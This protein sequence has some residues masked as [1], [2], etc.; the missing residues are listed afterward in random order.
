MGWSIRVKKNIFGNF[1]PMI[2]MFIITII[3]HFFKAKDLLIIG[4]IGIIPISWHDMF[5]KKNSIYNSI[6]FIT[7]YI[8][9]YG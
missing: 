4:V 6:N 1:I 7:Y 3:S 8:F 9:N 5:Y 2:T